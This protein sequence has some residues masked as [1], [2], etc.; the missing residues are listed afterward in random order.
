VSEAV[1]RPSDNAIE[2]ARRLAAGARNIVVLTGAGIST[3]SGIP[4]FR[5]PQGVWTRDP[6]AERLSSIEHYLADRELRKRA[7]RRR[8]EHAALEA[9]PNDG[10][11]AVVHLDTTGRL[12]LVVTQNV[13]GLHQRAGLHDDRV[14]EMHGS[15]RDAVC[16]QCR[17]RGPMRPVL[18]RVEAGEEDPPCEV[19][20]GILKSATVLFGEPLDAAAV[21]RAHL[22]LASS[23]LLLAVGSTLSVHPVAALVPMAVRGD[24]PVVI[25]NG[26]PTDMDHVAHAVVRGAI[27]EVLPRI[28]A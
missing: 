3:E 5:G 1:E 2:E 20:G 27:G 8:V 19:C 12:E 7:W 4:D 26:G 16:V 18:G 21:A 23:D 14:V 25:V 22:A 13:D 10:H 6:D 11:R 24:I 15:I 9:E 28:V 17:W